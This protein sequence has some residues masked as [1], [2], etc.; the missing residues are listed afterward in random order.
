VFDKRFRFE[1]LGKLFLDRLAASASGQLDDLDRLVVGRPVE[2]A[3]AS[4]DP[5]VARER[6]DVMFGGFARHVHYVYEPL[7]AA[8]SYA[9]RLTEPALLLVADFGG[10]TSD[11]SVVQVGEPGAKPRCRPLGHAGSGWQATVSTPG[12]SCRGWERAVAIAPSTRCSRYPAAISPISG[13]GRN[14]H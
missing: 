3:G 5:D 8:F 13:I 6:Y 11:F 10:G 1:A 12:S 7:G 9:S 4:P 2:Y 14:S